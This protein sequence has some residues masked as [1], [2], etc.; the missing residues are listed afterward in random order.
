MKK[1][2]SQFLTDIEVI[3]QSFQDIPSKEVEIWDWISDEEEDQTARRLP[4]EE[5]TGIRQ[6]QI[7]P[8]EMLTDKQ[9]EK[10]YEALGNLLK[11]INYSI[12]FQ[13][14][15]PL[16]AK[17]QILQ[18]NWKQEAIQK[19]WHYGFFNTCFEKKAHDE[20]IMGAGC[21]CRYFEEL[22]ASFEPDNRTPEEQ[23]AAELE[24]ELTHIKRKHGDDYMKYYPY[25]LDPKYDDE[26]GNPYDY[27]FGDLE[28]DEDE[29]DWWK[30]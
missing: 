2:L 27:G 29:D 17:Y 14:S 1:Y 5:W 26:N 6:E 16:R 19:A 21:E 9:I 4:L 13:F 7:P 18:K 24:I 20:C 22:H 11:A 30:K 25:H 10:L 12:V 28:E 23:R 3:T 15:I 8:A